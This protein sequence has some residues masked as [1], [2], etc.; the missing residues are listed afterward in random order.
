MTLLS[1]LKS[2][3]NIVQNA[4]NFKKIN[5]NKMMLSIDIFKRILIVCKTFII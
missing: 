5:N 2:K 3:M 4:F 1:T